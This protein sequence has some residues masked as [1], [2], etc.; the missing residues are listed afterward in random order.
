MNKKNQTVFISKEQAKKETRWFLLDAA[1][2]NL[3]RFASEVANILRGKHKPDFTPNIDTGDGVII[4][5]ADQIQ[6]TGAKEAQK[7]YRYYTG[8]IGG[9]RA[10]PY[11]VMMEKHPERIIEHAVRGMV[12]KTKLGRK[13]L[14]KLRIFAKADHKMEAQQPIVVNS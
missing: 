9:M 3:G 12:P 14:K 8:Y 5:N 11:R 6:V 13:Q 2:K 7:E 1:G 4:I 10:I